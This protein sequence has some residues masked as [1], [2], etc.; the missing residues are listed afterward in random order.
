MEPI[1]AA[2]FDDSRDLGA[3]AVVREME[4]GSEGAFIQ[5]RILV[6]LDLPAGVPLIQAHSTVSK[7][8]HFS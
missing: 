1:E 2:H 8:Y 3:D 6:K 7:V 4:A 5:Q